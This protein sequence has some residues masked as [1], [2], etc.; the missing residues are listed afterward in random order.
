MVLAGCGGPGAAINLY[1]EAELLTVTQACG[2]FLIKRLVGGQSNETLL[3][4]KFK[5]RTHW[6]PLSNYCIKLTLR[7]IEPEG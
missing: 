6:F 2:D 4:I 3:S 1:N 5:P 7:F